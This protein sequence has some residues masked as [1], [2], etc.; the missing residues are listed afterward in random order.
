MSE[1][2]FEAIV[3]RRFWQRTSFKLFA[4]FILFCCIFWGSV[5]YTSHS[6]FCK[7][8]HVMVPYYQSWT[9]S[10]H[11]NV[12]CILCHFEPGI[13]SQ[14]RGKLEGLVQLVNYFSQSYKKRKPWA[15]ISDK[16]CL[17]STCHGDKKFEQYSIGFKGVSYSHK[18]HLGELRRGKNLQCT[19][20]HSQIVQGEH[21][22]VSESTCFLCH[23]KKST[24]PNTDRLKEC[25]LCHKDT[26]DIKS[27]SNQKYDH[28]ALV[29]QNIE[30][31]TCHGSMA[32][33][34][35]KVPMENCYSCHWEKKQHEKYSDTELVHT[36]HVSKHRVECVRCHSPIEHRKAKKDE[37]LTACSSCHLNVHTAEI[38][39]YFGKDET[40][41]EPVMGIKEK[42][43]IDCQGCHILH[44]ELSDGTI[45][46]ASGANVCERCHTQTFTRVF[47]GWKNSSENKISRYKGY[48]K[49]IQ[50]YIEKMQEG[51]EKNKAL[52]SIKKIH[53]NIVLLERGRS[54]HNIGFAALL[55]S[56]TVAEFSDLSE[57]IKNEKFTEIVSQEN[58]SLKSD[59]MP[60]HY[61]IEETTVDFKDY[62]VEGKNIFPHKLHVLGENAIACSSCHNEQINFKAKGHGKLIK[63]A[64]ELCTECH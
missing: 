52:E 8:C 39:M 59:C 26:H 57:I 54:V 13:D 21:I 31:T 34:E 32:I 12:E 24:L 18:N 23:F 38:N 46:K 15:E 51:E 58:F 61:G 47:E 35:G 56:K 33:G 7:S 1:K 14:I 53:H 40:S 48:E 30:C 16:S 49:K 64:S 43:H 6:S 28:T 9:E 45:A 17:R 44:K 55:F 10:K 25:T 11:A 20:C 63:V 3:K 37:L 60:C 29:S 50:L 41:H 5:E 27:S 4:L 22:K 42:L 62:S 19:S 36:L 2:K